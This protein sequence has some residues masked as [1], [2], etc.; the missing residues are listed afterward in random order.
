MCDLVLLKV[1]TYNKVTTVDYQKRRI[2]KTSNGANEPNDNISSTR[3]SSDV[4]IIETLSPK[5][6]VAIIALALPTR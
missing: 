4:N 5:F 6:L 1:G 3:K 2:G